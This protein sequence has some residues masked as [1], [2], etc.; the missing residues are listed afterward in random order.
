MP[1]KPFEFRKE[2]WLHRHV[3]IS[4]R[5]PAAHQETERWLREL[6]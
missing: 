4:L 3:V 1:E 5:S 6:S 2:G